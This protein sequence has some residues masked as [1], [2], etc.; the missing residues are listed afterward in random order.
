MPLSHDQYLFLKMKFANKE[1]LWTF[2]KEKAVST[3]IDSHLL[4]L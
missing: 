1:C 4:P 3:L 2:M